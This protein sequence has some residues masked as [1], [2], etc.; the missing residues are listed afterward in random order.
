MTGA[1]TPPAFELRLPVDTTDTPFAYSDTTGTLAVELAV[2]AGG[3]TTLLL[4]VDTA[5][6]WAAD[7]LTAVAVAHRETTGAPTTSTT[8]ASTTTPGWCSPPPATSPHRA[9]RHRR[10]H[11]PR[12]R[13]VPPARGDR[14]ANTSPP[15]TCAP[16]SSRLSAA[17]ST[18]P[19]SP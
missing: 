5:R 19:A 11:R 4:P 7:L 17:G 1:D 15:P 8:P 6:T 3:Y 14:K 13:A 10:R 2:A 16:A 18:S 12:P 9:R